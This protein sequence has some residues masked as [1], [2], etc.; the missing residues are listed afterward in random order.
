MSGALDPLYVAARRV[1]LDALAALGQHTDAMVLVGAQAVYI[2]AGEA[3]V[4]V[5]PFTTDGDLAIDPRRLAPTPLLE[6]ALHQA[7]F[8]LARGK[9]GIWATSIDVGGVARTVTVDLLVPESLSGPGRRAARIP[10]HATDVARKASGLEAALVDCGQLTLHSLDPRDHR[11]AE[12]KV[13]G[14]AAL[15]VAKTHKVLDRAESND[16]LNDKDALDVYRLLR[17]V[18]TAE[19]ASRIRTL[20]T[21]DVSR[22]VTR[23]ALTEL[24]RLFGTARSVGCQMAARAAGASGNSDTV[25]ASLAVLAQDLV[26]LVG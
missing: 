19:L 5:A 25:S 9:V 15:I 6:V 22:A 24:P 18:P 7:H 17:V 2:H 1:L 26:E 23:R 4:A 16:R 12:L 21:H 20:L 10:P 3:D 8:R 14:P 11:Q 13:A